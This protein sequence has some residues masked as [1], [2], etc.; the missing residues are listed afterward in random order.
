MLEKIKRTIKYIVLSRKDPTLSEYYRSFGVK[1][2]NNCSFVGRNISFSSEPYL[3]S[4]GD[5]VRVSFDVCFITHD[6]GTHVLRRMYPN[7]SLYGRI[8]VGNNV[9]IGARALIM[10]NVNIGNNCIIGAGSIVTKDVKDG[11]IVAGIPAKKISSISEYFYKHE[12]DLLSIADSDYDE[13]KK[14]LLNRYYER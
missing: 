6:G 3:I 9:F 11:D 7:V 10:P 13:K 12:N 5:N 1:I 14:I 8:N 4:L 2:G